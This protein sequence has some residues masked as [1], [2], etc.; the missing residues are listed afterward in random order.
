MTTRRQTLRLFLRAAAVGAWPAAHAV[1]AQ[2]RLRGGYLVGDY[3]EDGEGWRG[4]DNADGIEA[5]FAAALEHGGELIEIDFPPGIYAVGRNVALLQPNLPGVILRAND[6]PVEFVFTADSPETGGQFRVGTPDLSGGALVMEGQFILRHNRPGVRTADAAMIVARGM[7]DY[8][9]TGLSVPCADNN[10]IV[11]GLN[12]P[13]DY[14]PDSVHITHC[15][16]GGRT[17]DG[18]HSHATI[19]DTAVRVL[20]PGLVTRIEHNGI[21]M[22]GD[23]AVLVG[24]NTSE[25]PCD[26]KIRH[27]DCQW[28]AGG[29]GLSFPGAEVTDNI[30]NGTLNAGIRA[31]VDT[32]LEGVVAKNTYV[33]RNTITRVGFFTEADAGGAVAIEQVNPFPIWLRGSGSTS[34]DNE[35]DITLTAAFRL[36]PPQDEVLE[37]VTST[38][39]RFNRIGCID[40]DG[41]LAANAAKKEIFRRAEGIGTVSNFTA[42]GAVITNSHQDLTYWRDEDQAVDSDVSMSGTKDGEPVS[43]SF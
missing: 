10:G 28:V 8:R 30:I 29:I 18:L 43:V 3:H 20:T 2:A 41:T 15:R 42:S 38:N 23:D 6:G 40:R 16:L 4:T 24:H 17:A 21:T 9:L 11:I 19:G 1:A 13:T 35:I 12:D 36:E 26:I 32:E 33:A 25:T 39:D 34:E 5:M 14:I 37:G 22:T 7:R 27:N 31:E